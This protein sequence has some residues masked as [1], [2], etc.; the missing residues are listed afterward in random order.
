MLS[1]PQTTYTLTGSARRHVIRPTVRDRMPVNSVLCRR[2]RFSIDRSDAQPK[3]FAAKRVFV[4]P[5]FFGRGNLFPP[6]SGE[7]LF[8]GTSLYFL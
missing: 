1:Q 8:D 6:V 5:K 7:C 3:Y 2:G 4:Y